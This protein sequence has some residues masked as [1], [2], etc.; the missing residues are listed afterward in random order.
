MDTTLTQVGCIA[1]NLPLLY[2]IYLPL[3][4]CSNGSVHDL[5]QEKMSEESRK[6]KGQL[7]VWDHDAG[8]CIMTII[9]SQCLNFLNYICIHYELHVLCFIKC[10]PVLW[11]LS[12]QTFCLASD[13]YELIVPPRKK[14]RT[15]VYSGP[16]RVTMQGTS[17][18]MYQLCA[19]SWVIS[20]IGYLCHHM[21]I[22]SVINQKW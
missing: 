14:S 19:S 10:C 7:W 22:M 5:H 2:F 17:S 6:R 13:S 9:V 18:Y 3:F 15:P 21:Q 11:C 16:K 8:K 12:L 4:V 1:V 20:F